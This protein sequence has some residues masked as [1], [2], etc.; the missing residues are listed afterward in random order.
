MLL[1]EIFNAQKSPYKDDKY[2]DTLYIC[3]GGKSAFAKTI[4]ALKGL[5]IDYRAVFDIDVLNDEGVIKNTY[6]ICGGDWS[7]EIKKN[8]D[9]L[10]KWLKANGS[11]VI[12][13][14]E[15]KRLINNSIDKSLNNV[16]SSQDIRRI[17]S[18]IKDISLDGF[19][20]KGI[21]YLDDMEIKSVFDAI[22]EK[23][24]Q[25]HIY[26]VPYGEIESFF[27]NIEGHSHSWLEKVLNTYKSF[28]APEYNKLKEFVGLIIK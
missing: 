17:K 28:D 23:L 3:T 9:L 6:K 4:K 26:L 19:K 20:E 22:N 8:Y 5:G 10:L 12:T 11:N 16:L 25:K 21:D 27:P 1:T 14:E 7:K 18:S 15:A 24:I 2:S 13:K